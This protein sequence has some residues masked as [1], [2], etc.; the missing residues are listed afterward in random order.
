MSD[1]HLIERRGAGPMADIENADLPTDK[2]APSK[3]ADALPRLVI[4][5][6]ICGLLFAWPLT[7]GL[8]LAN[9]YPSHITWLKIIIVPAMLFGLMGSRS[10]ADLWLRDR[11]W[12]VYWPLVLLCAAACLFLIWL[13]SG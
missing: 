9:L 3:E 5:A 1:E 6:S 2:E 8:K 12:I 13:A 11:A 7:I 4:R 10:A